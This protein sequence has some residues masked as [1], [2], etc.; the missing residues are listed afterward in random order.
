LPDEIIDFD[1]PQGLDVEGDEQ[2]LYFMTLNQVGTI[3]QVPVKRVL[4]ASDTS[5]LNVLKILLAGPTLEESRDGLFSLIPSETKVLSA[6]A[7]GHTA[8][9]DFSEEFLI[10]TYGIEGYAA[11]LKQVV[12]TASEFSDIQD[13]QI[14]IEGRRRNYLSEEILINIPISPIDLG[15]R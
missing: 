1:I 9:I 15:A 13:V 2:T 4:P 11:Q 10:N 12:F 6:T 14:L 8:Y 3:T 5:L 7:R